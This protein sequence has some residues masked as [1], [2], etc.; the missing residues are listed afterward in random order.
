MVGVHLQ[1]RQRDRELSE[2]GASKAVVRDGAGG[3]LLL[4]ERMS[5]TVGPEASG[6]L[7]LSSSGVL[8]IT[9]PSA[10]TVATTKPL[11]SS[12]AAAVVAV[13]SYVVV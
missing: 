4:G 1:G 2:V 13:K 9:P 5:W 10:S 3:W 12:V 7:P 8:L 6:G 11:R